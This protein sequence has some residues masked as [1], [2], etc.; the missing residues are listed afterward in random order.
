[1]IWGG[2]ILKEVFRPKSS[3][4]S[5]LNKILFQRRSVKQAAEG[6]NPE[7]FPPGKPE[8]FEKPDFLS[9]K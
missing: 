2:G 9:Q 3:E 1:M 5:L 6:H 4:L 7:D 8:H